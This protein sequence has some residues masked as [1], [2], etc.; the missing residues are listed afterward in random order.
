LPLVAVGCRE[1]DFDVSVFEQVAV[2]EEKLSQALAE[3]SAIG[4]IEEAVILSTCLRT[5]IYAV[6]DQFH[7]AIDGVKNWFFKKSRGYDVESKM[8]LAYDDAAAYH[9]FEVAS[10]LDSSVLG[11][12]EILGQVKKAI[13]LAKTQG[14]A[15][16][17]LE[18]LFM[19]AIK[20]GRKVR[21]L[22]GISKG[23]TSMAD[24]A[25]ALVKERLGG[26]FSDS[27]V[28]VIGA[29][30][31]G[32]KITRALSKQRGIKELVVA[33][34]SIEKANVLAQK[35]NL[36][37]ITF[38]ELPKVMPDSDVI[39]SAA[40]APK[41]FLL[42]DD[43]Y[44]MNSKKDDKVIVVDMGIPRNV[45]PK[46]KTLSNLVLLDID[47]VNS[48][49]DKN[50]NNRKAEI[51]SAKLIL[52]DEFNEYKKQS[53]QH[54]MTPIIIALKNDAEQKRT[55]VFN[56][57]KKRLKNISQSDMEIIEEFSKALAAKLIH[58]PTQAIKE[59]AGTSRQERF[60][61]VL[62]ALFRL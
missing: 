6:V 21:T 55:E 13:V 22:T 36:K 28:L 20:A 58:D 18:S 51:E 15:G 47:D 7:A 34:R 33:N 35:Y 43:F 60:A 9:L 37:A 62:R 44:T 2:S 54:L 26:T 16:P 56:K 30:E 48:Y 14:I 19:S 50:L 29:G 59:S 52:I 11:E 27:R 8:Y 61:Q 32:G 4:Q 3:V 17:A 12:P 45:D 41:A 49:T 5:E 42:V 46:V 53:A 31:I 1:R 38:E 57:Y 39:L 24:S 40:A 25:V 10:G 23:S